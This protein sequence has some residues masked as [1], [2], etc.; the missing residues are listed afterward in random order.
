[1]WS[2]CLRGAGLAG[3]SGSCI[4]HEL[5]SLAPRVAAPRYRR[6][7]H[8]DGRPGNAPGLEP[9]RLAA[10]ISGRFAE[11]STSNTALLRRTNHS[12]WLDILVPSANCAGV[13]AGKYF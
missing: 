11:P 12:T 6:V 9:L 1:M 7:S 10:R 4:A 5:S 13:Q 8:N 2:A 3:T